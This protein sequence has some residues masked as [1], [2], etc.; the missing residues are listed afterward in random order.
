MMLLQLTL[1]PGLALLRVPLDALGVL[2]VEA[3]GDR[4]R[5][6][7]SPE[8]AGAPGGRWPLFLLLLGVGSVLRGHRPCEAQLVPAPLR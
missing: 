1:V 5:A 6:A 3:F 8:R 2:R 7:S 4:R